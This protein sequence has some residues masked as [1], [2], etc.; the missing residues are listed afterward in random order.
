MSGLGAHNIAANM[1]T[2]TKE[3]LRVLETNGLFGAELPGNRRTASN[4]FLTSVLANI[5]DGIVSPKYSPTNSVR[6][7]IS[8]RMKGA[9]PPASGTFALA[10]SAE[11]EAALE[12]IGFIK[13][14]AQQIYANWSTSPGKVIDTLLD[15][16]LAHVT[17][18]Y[19]KAGNAGSTDITTAMGLTKAIQ[20]GIFDPRY[21]KRQ[22]LFSTGSKIHL[23]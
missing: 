1:G 18:H 11:T 23:R 14:T 2:F 4:V 6:S 3:Q 8:V 15:Y 10:I 21:R 9:S 16:A 17:G 12:S 5:A 19:V 22:S 20:D 7:P 13:A